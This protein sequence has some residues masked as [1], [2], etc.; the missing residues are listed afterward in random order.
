MYKGEETSLERVYTDVSART[1][2][3]REFRALFGSRACAFGKRKRGRP[4]AGQ[5]AARGRQE[6]P[7]DP[8]GGEELGPGEPS[9]PN[10][11]PD[12]NPRRRQITGRGSFPFRGVTGHLPDARRANSATRNV[13]GRGTAVFLEFL[14]ST[15]VRVAENSR[16][17]EARIKIPGF[18]ARLTVGET[19]SKISR[20]AWAFVWE[21]GT[22]PFEVFRGLLTQRLSNYIL[23]IV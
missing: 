6:T 7:G 5:A 23:E 17:G 13:V 22:V 4:I 18:P 1:R 3:S 15:G 21:R 2:C 14:K 20:C 19:E 8:R 12:A 11:R 16:H 10:T 9:P